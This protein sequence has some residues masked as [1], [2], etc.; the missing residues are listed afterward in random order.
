MTLYGDGLKS[1]DSKVS[2]PSLLDDCFL[3]LVEAE[4]KAAAADD[5]NDDNDGHDVDGF[6]CSSLSNGR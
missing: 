1:S 2:S 5:D 4:G 3:V 6:I